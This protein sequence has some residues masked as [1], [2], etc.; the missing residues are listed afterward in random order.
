VNRNHRVG[1]EAAMPAISPEEVGGVALGEPKQVKAY[2]DYIEIDLELHPADLQLTS[3]C[4]KLYRLPRLSESYSFIAPEPGSG[5]TTLTISKICGQSLLELADGYLEG[6][7]ASRVSFADLHDRGMVEVVSKN[8]ASAELTIKG[9][10]PGLYTFT[11]DNGVAANILAPVGASDPLTPE[12][13]TRSMITCLDLDGVFSDV[14]TGLDVY[15]ATGTRVLI[16]DGFGAFLDFTDERKTVLGQYGALSG[17]EKHTFV[18]TPKHDPA[19]I[20]KVDVFTYKLVHAAAGEATGKIFVRIGSE[21]VDLVWDNNNPYAEARSVEAADDRATVSIPNLVARDQDASSDT[22]PIGV[23]GNVTEND[24]LASKF[25]VL[26]VSRDG[27]TYEVPAADGTQ[28]VGKH[29]MLTIHADGSYIYAPQGKLES[30]G[31]SDTFKYQLH[32]PNAK[33]VEAT[34][35]VEIVDEV[36]DRP[37]RLEENGAIDPL[38]QL[39]ANPMEELQVDSIAF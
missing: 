18:Y 28:L 34:L 2:D 16:D 22:A 39:A 13:Q 21:Q 36:E 27:E 19:N 5:D 31:H 35:T 33:I 37:Q 9:L 3:N 6:P 20:G 11:C 14:P 12:L 23:F 32:C 30:I 29:G 4:E 17:R 25:T 38:A 26:A 7:G 10:A 8:D 15:P 1:E 24:H